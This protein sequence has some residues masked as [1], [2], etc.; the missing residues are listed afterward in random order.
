MSRLQ[1]G[2]KFSNEVL[3]TLLM[4]FSGVRFTV[5]DTSAGWLRALSRFLDQFGITC[6]FI[7]LAIK[8]LLC[9]AD[10]ILDL[11]ARGSLKTTLGKSLL[12]F[13][14][15]LLLIC[16]EHNP[17]KRQQRIGEFKLLSTNVATQLV[18]G[19]DNASAILFTVNANNPKDRFFEPTIYAH[20]TH[21]S[22]TKFYEKQKHRKGRSKEGEDIWSKAKA[23]EPITWNTNRKDRKIF[24]RTEVI[25]GKERKKKRDYKTF[26]TVPTYAGGTIHGLLTISSKHKHDLTYE[27]VAIMQI[28]AQG[29]S[30]ALS[31]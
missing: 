27:D 21:Q 6:L 14:S 13:M 9:I 12:E 15:S 28:L 25:G 4:T 31:V 1:K 30:C 10:Y 18:P 16:A 24:E 23:H 8:V 26:I 7:S 17:T 11:L 19:K 5:S 20:G 3:I 2:V 22:K 29:L